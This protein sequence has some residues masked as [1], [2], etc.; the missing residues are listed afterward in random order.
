MAVDDVLSE[1][2]A[3]SESD[4]RLFGNPGESESP[5]RLG[6]ALATAPDVIIA[7]DRARRVGSALRKLW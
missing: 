7:R 6:V 2:L 5:R 4:V 3:T 1:A